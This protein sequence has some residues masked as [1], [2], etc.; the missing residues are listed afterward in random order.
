VTVREAALKAHSCYVRLKPAG[1]VL[2]SADSKMN[3]F[4]EELKKIGD[5]VPVNNLINGLKQ[6][7]F[8]AL[9]RIFELCLGILQKEV[10]LVSVV[11]KR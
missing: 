4:I 8:A 5:S 9:A 2:S 6:I 10:T 3:D 1:G 11:V 7:C